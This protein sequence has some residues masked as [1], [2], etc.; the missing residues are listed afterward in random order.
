MD[1]GAW[2]GTVHGVT[3]VGHDLR[4]KPNQTK[5]NNTWDWPGLFWEDYLW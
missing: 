2:W 1:R 5:Y 3:S 4:T